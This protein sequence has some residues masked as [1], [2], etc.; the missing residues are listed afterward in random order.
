MNRSEKNRGAAMVIVLCVMV[1]FLALSTTILLAGSVTLN[2]ARNSIYFEYG[3]AQAVSLSELFARD[4]QQ[5]LSDAPGTVSGGAA[6]VENQSLVRYVRDEIVKKGWKPYDEEAGNEGEAIKRFTLDTGVGTEDES[7]HEIRI[8]MYWT[9]EGDIDETNIK[10]N[11]G[12]LA[13][14][15]VSLFIDVYSVL[16]DAEYHVKREFH[17]DSMNDNTDAASWDDY[18]YLWTWKTMGRSEER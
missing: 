11:E 2:N 9:W 5:K 14:Q 18:P 13:D 8:A 15:G 3:K 6:G 17:L 4:M 7:K 12:D 16:N 1:V 10:D